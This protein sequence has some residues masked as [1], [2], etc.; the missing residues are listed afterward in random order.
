MPVRGIRGAIS[1]EEDQPDLILE[2]TRELLE[3]IL[4]ANPSLDPDEIASITFTLTPD[5]CSVH[6][7]QAAR[8]MGWGQV[9]LLCGLEIAVPDSLPKVLRVL[10]HWNTD[11][12]QSEI[13][14]MYLRKAIV[15]RPDLVST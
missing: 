9:P 6:P 14:H 8:K 11:L 10:I 1:I 7:A 3:A 2:A 5:L 13:R 4:Q 12:L 15:L